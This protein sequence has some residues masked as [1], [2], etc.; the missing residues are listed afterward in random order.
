MATPRTV[1]FKAPLCRLSYAKGLFVAE[2]YQ[3]DPNATLKFT[4]SFI[5]PNKDKAFF[6]PYILEVL[7]QMDKG[8]ERFK[9]DMDALKAGFKEK[10]VISDAQVQNLSL[11]EQVGE[12]TRMLAGLDASESGRAHAEELLAAAASSKGT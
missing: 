6:E 1:D 10:A 12:L 2:R 9:T 3:G 11:D 8:V 4:P 7:K 5:W